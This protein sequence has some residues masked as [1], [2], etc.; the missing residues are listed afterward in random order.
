MLGRPD[1]ASPHVPGLATRGLIRSAAGRGMAAR[2]VAGGPRRNRRACGRM[3]IF[4][5]PIGRKGYRLQQH[6]VGLLQGK[7][8]MA[9][10]R[11]GF[12][13]LTARAAPE[14]TWR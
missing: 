5:G 8:E 3:R 4:A 14:S 6:D 12:G 11:S 1:A 13:A 2:L 7:R 10:S 9:T